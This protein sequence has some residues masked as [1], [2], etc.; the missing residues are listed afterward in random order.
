MCLASIC[1]AGVVSVELVA[2]QIDNDYSLPQLL[3]EQEG[4][5]KEALAQELENM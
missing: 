4:G 2:N 5:G 3:Q 1:K